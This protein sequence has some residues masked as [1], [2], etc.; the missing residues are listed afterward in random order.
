ML[1]LISSVLV[2]LN[3]LKTIILRKLMSFNMVYMARVKLFMVSTPGIDLYTLQPPVSGAVK[4]VTFW[5]LSLARS[6][7]SGLAPYHKSSF[8]N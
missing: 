3:G 5:S 4:F 2:F 6:H 8:L 7:I 1:V